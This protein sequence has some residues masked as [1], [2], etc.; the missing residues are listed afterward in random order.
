MNN[1]HDIS[2]WM[3]FALWMIVSN[4]PTIAFANK[5]KGEKSFKSTIGD[6]PFSKK[7]YNT[8]LKNKVSI[9]K[10]DNKKRLEKNFKI[11]DLRGDSVKQNTQIMQL[12]F[13]AEKENDGAGPSSP[14]F[15][16][17]EAVSTDKMV[18][19]FTGDFTYN[20]PLMELPGAH[21][22][23][24]P[25]TLSYHSG[26]SPDE[27]ASWVGH[28]F[29]LSPGAINRGKRGFPDDVKNAD[30]SYYN[31]VP[32]NFTASVRKDL[33]A[34]IWSVDLSKSS[35]FSF[36]NYKGIRKSKGYGVGFG[37]ASL[38]F[39]YDNTSIRTFL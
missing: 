4:A 11:L 10:N 37:G 31:N 12:L 16:S 21:S 6:L 22:G 9:T 32:A 26:V 7:N 8:K 1:K 24:Y 35:T 14:E 36:N 18:D 38:N 33:A 13:N 28:G 20:L 29:T 15:S 19:P 5:N 25:I 2:A 39:N 30:V 17:F 23:G 3:F 27:D 34:E